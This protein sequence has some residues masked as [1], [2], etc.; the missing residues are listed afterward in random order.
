MISGI[1]PPGATQSLMTS[2][3]C[4]TVTLDS[5]K[6]LAA[7]LAV[8]WLTPCLRLHH[9]ARPVVRVAISPRSNTGATP[10]LDSLVLMGSRLAGTRQRRLRRE[11]LGAV[12]GADAWKH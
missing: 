7:C 4:L 2:S 11:G 3:G 10:E 5:S 9:L 12:P 6:Q 1:A 8:G